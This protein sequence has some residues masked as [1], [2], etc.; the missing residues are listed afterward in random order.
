[1]NDKD[2]NRN[3]RPKPA[4]RTRTRRS[5]SDAQKQ[6]ILDQHE[7]SGLTAAR[8]IAQTGLPKGCLYRW[9]GQLRGNLVP[10][11]SDK[12][13]LPVSISEE[14]YLTRDRSG[15]EPTIVV[16]MASG[17]FCLDVPVGFCKEHLRAV[18]SVLGAPQC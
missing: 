1:M 11:G 12:N 6:D 15:E 5:W 3:P 18:L 13:L 16:R 2:N 7:K 9:R 17:P 10:R 8:F 4:P 14:K